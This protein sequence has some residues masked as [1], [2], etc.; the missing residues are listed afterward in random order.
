MHSDSKSKPKVCPSERIL[1]GPIPS[2]A[3]GNG[4]VGEVTLGSSEM[5]DAFSERQCGPGF[6]APLGAPDLDGTEGG[7]QSLQAFVHEAGAVRP[8]AFLFRMR[9]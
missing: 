6:A 3:A 5:N 9:S 7:K 2:A 4:R 8:G 1:S